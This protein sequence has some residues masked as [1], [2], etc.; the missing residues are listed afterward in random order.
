[1]N[2][3]ESWI[4]IKCLKLTEKSKDLLSAKIGHERAKAKLK[5][6]EQLVSTKQQYE[7]VKKNSH[8]F[9]NTGTGSKRSKNQ[10]PRAAS[11]KQGGSKDHWP[12]L[13][14][15]GKTHTSGQ[16]KSGS[17]QNRQS[18]T[19]RGPITNQ[20]QNQVRQNQQPHPPPPPPLPSS[21]RRWET[22][23]QNQDSSLR[24]MLA[25][26]GQ[27]AEELKDLKNNSLQYPWIDPENDPDPHDHTD[28]IALQA[29]EA[30][31][32]DGYPEGAEVVPRGGPVIVTMAITV[33]ITIK[34]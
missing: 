16:K 4:L 32:G 6:T 8:F 26:L 29:G 5:Y 9:K 11:P 31:A 28:T 22:Q 21:N 27:Q 25:R 1:M 33:T 20:N 3:A 12:K 30:E 10:N 17:V 7:N 24:K 15:T 19:K 18:Q 34:Q 14:N 2:L 23:H 13:P